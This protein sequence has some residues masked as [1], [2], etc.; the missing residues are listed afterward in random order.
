MSKC[1]FCSRENEGIICN[2]HMAVG[3]TKTGEGV[4][5]VGK[6]ALYVV[7][8]VITVLTRQKPKI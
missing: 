6:A 7:P 8:L 1:I 2:H 5:K 4:K 3:L